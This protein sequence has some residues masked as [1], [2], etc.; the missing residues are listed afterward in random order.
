MRLHG[1]EKGWTGDAGCHQPVEISGGKERE[2]DRERERERERESDRV[3][4]TQMQTTW[5]LSHLFI[6]SL[7]LQFKFHSVSGHLSNKKKTF[8]VILGIPLKLG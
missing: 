2:G 5:Y 8:H 6:S 4:H 3:T 1:D 7:K